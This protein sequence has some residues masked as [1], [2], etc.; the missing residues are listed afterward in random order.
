MSLE[1]KQLK[2]RIEIESQLYIKRGKLN[3]LKARIMRTEE[4]FIVQF[5][6]C[7]R[8][9]EYYDKRN[10]LLN[11]I[12][13][14][15]NYRKKNKLGLILGFYIAP[16]TVGTNVYIAH[17]GSILI[18]GNS[19]VGDNCIFHGENCIGNDSKEL[20]KAPVIGSGV[21]IGVGAKIIGDI[22]IADGIFIGANA[23]VTKSFLEPGI[24]IAGVPAK[25]ISNSI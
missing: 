7:L 10:G 2:E 17:A 19:K 11:R 1:Y 20:S 13:V 3:L 5:L 6:R 24:T 21:D 9:I 16:H 25:K 12:K 4:Y 22:Y 23:V 14:K 8:K 15:W 18:N